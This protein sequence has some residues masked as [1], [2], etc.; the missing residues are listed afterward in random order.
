MFADYCL[1]PY[2]AKEYELG[3]HINARVPI[4]WSDGRCSTMKTL[5]KSFVCQFYSFQDS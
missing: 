5:R 3:F 1:L 2:F 4:G